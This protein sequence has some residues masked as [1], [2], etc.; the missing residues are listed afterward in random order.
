MRSKPMARNLS[1]ALLPLVAAVALAT[2]VS[3]Q[4]TSCTDPA[5]GKPTD[6]VPA[7]FTTF[8]IPFDKLPGGRMDAQGNLDPTSSPKDAHAGA[9]VAAKKLGLFRNFEWL[10]WVPTAPSTRD[11][12]TGRWRGGDLDGRPAR[13]RDESRTSTARAGDRRPGHSGGRRRP[14]DRQDRL[15]LERPALAPAG[16]GGEAAGRVRGAAHPRAPLPFPHRGRRCRIA[17]G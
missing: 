1:V 15:R 2:R 5:S 7:T 12:A 10:H 6:C 9:F 16:V 8:D 14:S 13:S 17:H 11:P 4:N 3:G